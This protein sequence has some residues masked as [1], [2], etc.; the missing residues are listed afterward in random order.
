MRAIRLTDSVP[1]ELVEENL[2]DPQPGQTELL[3]RVYAAGVIRTE[4]GWYPTTHTKTGGKR[5]HAVPG[6]EFSGVIADLGAGAEGFEIGQEVYGM[7]DWYADGATAEYCITQPSY[8]A[9]KPA[10]LTHVQAASVPI[11]AMTAWQ[12]LYDRAKLQAGESVLV[13]GGAGGVGMFAIQL[14]RLRGARVLA[15]AS[16]ANL[17]FVSSWEPNGLSITRREV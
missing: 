7:N 10:A 13:Q 1:P 2:P 3:I 17:D 6:H 12:G 11:S 4:L 14:A 16:A 5:S 15:T 9:P 8:I